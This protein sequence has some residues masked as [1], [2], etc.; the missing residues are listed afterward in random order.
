VLE[1]QL[2]YFCRTSSVVSG[3]ASQAS[4][5]EALRGVI[6]K[7]DRRLERSLWTD[8]PEEC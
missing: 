3:V 6:A 1:N 4:T 8:M 5:P 2:Q 7:A